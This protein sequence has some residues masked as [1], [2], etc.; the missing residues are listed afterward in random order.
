MAL[1]VT[2]CFR[3][4]PNTYAT[5]IV[6]LLISPLVFFILGSGK[7]L[8][9]G[10]LTALLPITI[11]V[12]IS[13]TGHLSGAGG[14]MISAFDIVLAILCIIWGIELA[15]K[16]KE[17]V[18]FFPCISVPAVLLLAVAGISAAFASNPYLSKYEILEVLKMYMA[19]LYLANNINSNKDFEWVI[20]ML[21]LGLLFEGVL[22]FAQHRYDE[23][24][25]PTS[26]GGPHWIESRVKGTWV[27]YN[28]FAWY[29]TYVLPIALSLLFANIRLRFWVLSF[30]ALIFGGG[31]LMWTG[32]RG[33]WVSFG[34]AFVF[35]LF[36]IYGKI[37]GKYAFV[38]TFLSIMAAVILFTPL[39]PRLANK[40]YTRFTYD[41]KGAAASRIPQ[42]EV[43]YDMIRENLLTGVGIN[44]YTEVMVRYDNTKEGLDSITPHAVHNIYL[45]IAAEMG[46]FGIIVFLSIVFFVYVEGLKHVVSS[47]DFIPYA[48]TGM[49]SGILAFLVHG[50]VDTASIGS[51]MFVFFWFYA[52]L[53]F[54][55]RNIEDLPH[56]SGHP[57][58]RSIVRSTETR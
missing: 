44:N 28:D 10:V 47:G 40:I 1:V 19:F 39:Y 50:M 45:H 2:F 24:F 41:D 56:N 27:S 30:A 54:G 9:T 46:I 14:Y 17:R 4:F 12:T 26:L 43:A 18:H 29:L 55:L 33:G 31:A 51:K 20:G 8:L 6:L 57:A 48:A 3:L 38:K 37:K 32:S 13:H 5:M 15:L 58:V 7:L 34:C 52:G 25:F 21:V 36:F 53:I 49:L 23:P 22:S 42:F 35:F 11:D 16:K